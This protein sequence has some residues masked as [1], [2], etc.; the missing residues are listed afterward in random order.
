VGRLVKPRRTAS[1]PQDDI[2]PYFAA[3][4]LCNTVVLIMKEML[5]DVERSLTHRINPE[6]MALATASDLECTCNFS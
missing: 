4:A 2:L 5:V 6:R 1:P 3:A